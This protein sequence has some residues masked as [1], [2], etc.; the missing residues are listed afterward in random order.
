MYRLSMSQLLNNKELLNRTSDLL[1]DLRM[2]VE[3]AFRH[4]STSSKHR[5]THTEGEGRGEADRTD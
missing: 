3:G 5:G 1:F 2:G 4:A